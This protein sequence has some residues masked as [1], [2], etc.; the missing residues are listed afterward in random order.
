MKFIFV[1]DDL[2][3]EVLLAILREEHPTHASS[4]VQ[5]LARARSAIWQSKFDALIIDI[6]MP[7]DDDAVSES[8]LHE[9]MYSGIR[10]AELIRAD[11]DGPNQNSPIQIGRA[12]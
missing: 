9:G 6:M 2:E 10:L 1:D 5:T 11:S 8:E 4:H 12:S 3:T 7:P